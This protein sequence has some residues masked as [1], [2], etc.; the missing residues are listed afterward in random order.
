M[1]ENPLILNVALCILYKSRIYLN[2]DFKDVRVRNVPEFRFFLKLA[3]Q[4]SVTPQN[5]NFLASIG[6]DIYVDFI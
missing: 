4:G 1:G 5:S 3:M 2:H 6:L